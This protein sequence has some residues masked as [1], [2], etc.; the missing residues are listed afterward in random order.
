MCYGL[1]TALLGMLGCGYTL[2]RAPT[3]APSYTLAPVRAPSAE[4]GLAEAVERALADAVARR[5]AL[6]SGPVLSAEV[7][8]AEVRPAAV[9]GAIQEA[10]LSI[11]VRLDGAEGLTVSASRA[12]PLG[13]DPESTAAL[14]AEA[15]SSLAA[16]LS[17]EAVLRL[18]G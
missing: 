7:L 2:G 13:A 9:G 17:A 4:P 12:F 5:A 8:S 3:A 14:R 16:E 1:L 6:G 15:F 11:R 18:L 10:R